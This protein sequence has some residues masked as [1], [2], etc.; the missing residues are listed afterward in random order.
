MDVTS[1]RF[2]PSL[3]EPIHDLSNPIAYTSHLQ[4]VNGDGYID[5]LSHYLT[6]QTGLEIGDTSGCL[7]GFLNDGTPIKGCDSVSIT[8]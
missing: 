5:L 1:L 7:E 6:M 2:C 4:D 3:A 8:Q